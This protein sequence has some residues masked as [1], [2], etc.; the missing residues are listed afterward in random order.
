[1]RL[2]AGG[3]EG[4]RGTTVRTVAAT[5]DAVEARLAE[6]RDEVAVWRTGNPETPWSEWL[7]A[8]AED[9]AWL[10]E[11]G[12]PALSNEAS[13]LLDLVGAAVP[14]DAS[15]GQ[16]VVQLETVGKDEALREHGGVRLMTIAKSKGLTFDTA[17][18]LGVEDELIP[19]NLDDLDEERRL[20]YVAITRAKRVTITSMATER[21]ERTGSILRGSV[22]STRERTRFFRALP[23][24]SLED[25]RRF[26]RE[27]LTD[28]EHA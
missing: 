13:H 21:K 23:S 19:R 14:L 9:G 27:R 10:D 25:G 7:K 4:I 17:L 20:L 2:R 11:L 28:V 8:E 15:L 22:G 1:M 16:F 12:L 5:I 18:V 3:F 24:V 6:L 26:V